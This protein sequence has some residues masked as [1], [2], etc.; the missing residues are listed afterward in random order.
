MKGTASNKNIIL[1]IAG[2]FTFLLF[3]LMAYPQSVKVEFTFNDAITKENLYLY[4]QETNISQ[5]ASYY[6]LNHYYFISD[7]NA[8]ENE[9]IIM[10]STE[11]SLLNEINCFVNNIAITSDTLVIDENVNENFI[12][13]FNL[14]M[15]KKSFFCIR[16]IHL[17]LCLILLCIVIFLLRRKK[18]L[19]IFHSFKSVYRIS[20]AA[21]LLYFGLIKILAFSKHINCQI[22][23]FLIEL[24]LFFTILCGI[25]IFRLQKGHICEKM[26]QLCFTFVALYFSC[27]NLNNFLTIDE[28]RAILEQADLQNDILRHLLYFGNARSNYLIMGSM[29]ELTPVKFLTDPFISN[30][31]MAKIIHWY[32]GIILLMVM[33]YFVVILMR[34]YLSQTRT[35]IVFSSTLIILTSSP[36]L[37]SALKNYNYDLYSMV[38]GALSI[39]I[40]FYALQKQKTAW[41]LAAISISILA[42]QEKMTAIPVLLV[43]IIFVGYMIVKKNNKHY[44]RNILLYSIG[45]SVM[46]GMELLGCLIFIDKILRKGNFPA[47]TLDDVYMPL[48]SLYTQATQTVGNP[49]Q[50]GGW[51]T[52][53]ILSAITFCSICGL[54]L[55]EIILKRLKLHTDFLNAR[56]FIF[57]GCIMAT[58]VIGILGTYVV[59]FAYIEGAYSDQQNA[60]I[61]D[62]VTTLSFHFNTNSFLE[63]KIR[64]IVAMFEMVWNSI[65]TV[66]LM[67]PIVICFLYLKKTHG[68]QTDYM[69]EN[70]F[71]IFGVLAPFA[72]GIISLTPLNR[73]LNVYVFIIVLVIL[74]LVWKNES[75]F[76]KLKNKIWYGICICCMIECFAFGPAYTSYW[77]IW[78]IMPYLETENVPGRML[79]NWRGGWGEHIY[80]AGKKIENYCLK[81]DIPLE[82]VVIYTNY[83]GSWLNNE[84]ELTIK[85]MPGYRSSETSEYPKIDFSKVKLDSTSFFVFSKWGLRWASTQYSLPENIPPLMEISYRGATECWIYT[86]SQLE[87]YF[88]RKGIIDAEHKSK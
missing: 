58:L 65:P 66:I 38:F 35:D 25:V 17:F 53:A 63:T 20:T 3:F 5:T 88:Q 75:Y 87:G 26:L 57:A 71:V 70:S 24:C 37:L 14:S 86:G 19:R 18:K 8:I 7:M 30:I 84:N 68:K 1:L 11:K 48:I 74:L 23:I 39:E 36:L 77:P 40:L 22:N 69:L 31:Q 60:Y 42:S 51:W 21:F 33:S 44:I 41:G 28:N 34:P 4:N 67:L 9:C 76:L 2:T 49:P 59:P 13:S 54:V 61:G 56:K 55:F 12:I 27:S 43:N 6:Y 50:N 64:Y 83:H 47:I 10:S 80:M 52:I 72:Y 73:Y 46:V 81:N 62:S 45:S 32:T 82:N 85:R 15:L 78:N 16:L 29:W 79:I